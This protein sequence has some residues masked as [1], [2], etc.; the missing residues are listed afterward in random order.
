M[1]NNN[2]K[3]FSSNS[4]KISTASQAQIQAL[5]H[6]SKPNATSVAVAYVNGLNVRGIIF[7]MSL[8]IQ[9]I[10]LPLMAVGR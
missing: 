8:R 5:H 4:M 6:V 1:M 9:P 2:N 3:S 7:C 10:S